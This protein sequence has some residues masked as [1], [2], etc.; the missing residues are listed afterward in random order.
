MDLDPTD[1]PVFVIEI[2]IFD[3]WNFNY[4]YWNFNSRRNKK[5]VKPKEIP[6]LKTLAACK[7]LN[8]GEGENLKS[9]NIEY[10]ISDT[11]LCKVC[12]SYQPSINERIYVNGATP[13]CKCG[14]CTQ[15]DTKI[16][17]IKGNFQVCKNC[18]PEDYKETSLRYIIKAVER[19]ELKRSIKVNELGIIVDAIKKYPSD[20]KKLRNHIITELKFCRKYFS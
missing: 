14:K 15:E 6:S 16:A 1:I 17:G 3:Y 13:K 5:T 9:T 20:L 10:I 7:L 8:R 19:F 18:Y 2:P 4:E 11:F 12:Y